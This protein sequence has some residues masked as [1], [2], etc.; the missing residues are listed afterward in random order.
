[1]KRLFGGKRPMQKI[2]IYCKHCRKKTGVSYFITGNPDAPALRGIQIVC[3]QKSCKEIIKVAMFMKKT[4]KM[5][6]D[7][8]VDGKIYI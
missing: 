7:Q 6:I 5:L 3:P 1:M 2:D 4:E 8:S